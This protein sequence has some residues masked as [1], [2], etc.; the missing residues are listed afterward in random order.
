MI[1]QEV[2]YSALRRIGNINRPGGTA[3][4]E[5]M[6]DSL[7]EWQAFADAWNT[8]PTMQVAN[9]DTYYPINTTGF[10][11]NSYQFTIGPS[12]SGA[13]LI[14]PTPERPVS[15]RKANWV[16]TINTPLQPQRLPIRLIDEE[17]WFNIIQLP[18]P[19]ALMA[20]YL[21]YQPKF[22]LGILNVW[23]PVETGNQIE[24]DTWGQVTWPATL[25]TTVVFPPGY[26][27]A[28]RLTLAEMMIGMGTIRADVDM[29]KDIAR[30]P[31]L[32]LAARQAVQRVNRVTPRL[33]SD[34]RRIGGGADYN[35][36]VGASTD[37]S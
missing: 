12:G 28:T 4:P 37:Y 22:P 36:L 20:V 32:A 24:L 15:I 29:H 8:D 1:A 13:D 11:N 5:I 19:G 16:W 27:Q 14:C 18:I 33:V 7:M 10:M 35:F 23:P 31:A 17:E 3:S 30:I 2:V 34:M 26:F 9:D 6:A 25:G 21:W